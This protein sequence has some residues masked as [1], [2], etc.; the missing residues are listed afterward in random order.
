MN[1]FDAQ[2]QARRSTRR[3]V[4]VYVVATI[5]I[6][7]GVTLVVAA[8]LYSGT[9]S[10]YGEPFGTFIVRQS[11][12]LIATAIIVTLVILCAT[13]AKTAALSAGGSR[14]ANDMGGTLV[15]PD[16]RDPLRRRLRNVVEEMAIASGVPV[17]EIYVLEKETAINA[18]A[19]GYAPGDAAI[20]VTRGTLELLD[21]DEL[22]GVIGHEFSHILNGDMRLNIRLMGVL[23]G[24]MVIGLAGRMV[25]RGGR[26]TGFAFSRRGKGAPVI[27]LVGVGLAILGGIGV[28]FARAIKASVSRQREYLADASAVQF[29][30]QTDG[31]ANALKKIGGFHAGSHLQAADPE[32]VSHMLFGTGSKLS[33]MF[34]THPPLTDRIRA[35]DPSFKSSDYPTVDVR[36]RSAATNSAKPERQRSG[37]T[38]AFAAAATGLSPKAV[39]ANVGHPDHQQIENAVQ[40]RRTFPEPLYDAAHSSDQAY[41]LAIALVLDRDGHVLGRQL[42]LAHEQLGEQR[43]RVVEQFYDELSKSSPEYRLPLLEISFPALRQRPLAEL[44]FLLDLA[45]RLIE[46]DGE[47]DLYEYCFYRVLVSS[48]GQALHPSRR[49]AHRRATREPVRRAAVDLLRIV[50]RH[51]HPDD[52]VQRRAFAAGV[53]NFGSWGSKFSFDAEHDYSMAVLDKSLELLLA[54]NGDGKQMLLEAVAAVVMSDCTLEVAEAE[55]IRAICASLGCPLPP[56]LGAK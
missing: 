35:L 2:D 43:V 44:E 34:A 20:A 21:R 51:G 7:L 17:P 50:A 1:F 48:L 54:L 31:L 29:T 52:A 11:A 41:L 15:S 30:R 22:Q 45:K 8:A 13:A 37:S 27:L 53:A 10:N 40:L 46:V 19:A 18:F 23:Y 9:Q 42:S 49:Q 32:E 25:L 55:L 36:S 38:S 28:F 14:V 16:V 12:T 56:I 3:L 26:H 4:A 5:L 6:V 39:A 24:I 33:G 47:I